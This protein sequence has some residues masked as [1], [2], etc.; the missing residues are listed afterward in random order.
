VAG[1]G[2]PSSR[3]VALKAIDHRGFL[4]TSP[5]DGPK[6]RELAAD[7]RAS[8]VLYWPRCHRQ[9]RSLGVVTR[10]DR[11]E[12]E[13]HFRARPRASQLALLVAPPSEAIAGR[14]TL[15][16]RLAR[17]EEEHQGRTLPMPDWGSYV[18]T[19]SIVEL[20]QGHTGRLHDRFRY[21][22]EP[23]GPWSLQRLAP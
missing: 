20:W 6:A 10:L 4:F 23:H 16:E 5:Y 8:L 15:E 13:R 22:R 14:H 3:T 7:Q 17:L 9:V 21:Q 19:P 11:D 12:S 2:G 18:L 1:D